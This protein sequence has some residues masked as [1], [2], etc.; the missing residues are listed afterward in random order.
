VGHCEVPTDRI[1]TEELK[2]HNSPPG[3]GAPRVPTDRIP[4]EELKLEQIN[5]N[6]MPARMV[7]TDRIPTE[8][9]KQPR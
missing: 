9:L 4:T 6:A 3:G 5:G 2:L 8:E 7:P 1:P